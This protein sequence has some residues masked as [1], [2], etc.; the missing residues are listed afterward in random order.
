MNAPGVLGNDTD[1]DGDSLTAAL[2]TSPSHGNVTQNPD[3]SFTYTPDANFCGTD[4][5]TYTANDG[6]GGSGTATVTIEVACQGRMTG[7]G[8]VF[9]EGKDK[10]THGFELHCSP[11]DKP[12][13]L[14]VNWG[15]GNKFHLENLTLAA[16][17]NA[18]NIDEAPPV[19]G[20]DTYVG[21]GDGRYNGVSGATATWIFTD[22][23]EPGKDT[24]FA[25]IVIEDASG[26][27]VLSVSG[28]L[29]QAGNHQAHDD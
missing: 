16:C 22:A 5:Y 8:S 3:G 12:N 25:E 13:N 26:E 11:E 6:N 1:A 10:V 14:E 29:K 20:F 19:A 28:F 2:A 21:A 24:D 15:K 9:G 23:G 4:S 27:V 18:D 7:G 17:S